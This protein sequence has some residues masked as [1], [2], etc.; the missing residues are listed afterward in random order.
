MEASTIA[1]LLDTKCDSVDCH[2]H[3]E[4]RWISAIV[5]DKPELAREI[6]QEDIHSS[7][8]LCNFVCNKENVVK[9]IQTQSSITTSQYIPDKAWCMAAVFNSRK[10]LQVMREFDVPINQVNHHGN[11]FLHSVIAY[12]SIHSEDIECNFLRNVAFMKSLLTE[13]EFKTVLLAEDNDGLRPLELA[14]HLGT[15]II[16]KFLFES[17][18]VYMAKTLD[19]GFYTSCSTLTSL[20]TWRVSD[21]SNRQP[22][23][24]CI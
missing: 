8:S 1:G 22:T 9:L 4:L 13:D 23:P 21:Y 24:W 11:T 5:Y 17:E 3:H 18:G 10:V 16:F 19:L 7:L 20:N 6:L 12:A 14:A 15:F 2:H